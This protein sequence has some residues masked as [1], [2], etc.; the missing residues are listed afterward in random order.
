MILL[1]YNLRNVA[2]EGDYE[3]LKSAKPSKIEVSSNI[4]NLNE[5]KY[6]FY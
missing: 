4:L 5:T 6:F 2:N 3:N 1:L